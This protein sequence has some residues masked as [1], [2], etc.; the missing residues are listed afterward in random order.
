MKDFYKK[1]THRHFITAFVII[2]II[3][4]VLLSYNDIYTYF[5]TTADALTLIETS[6][7]QS[8][9]DIVR[10]FTKHMMSD[11][12]FESLARYYRPI[13]ML[14]FSLDY[15]IWKLNPL[16]YHLTDLIIH[17]LVSITVFFLMQLLTGGRSFIAWVI[18]IIFT[19]HPAHIEVV[20]GIARRFDT[21]STLCMIFSLLIFLK[22]YHSP[23]YK[24]LL[25]SIF[26]YLLAL[27]SKESA[28]L[29]SPLI[30]IY[31]IIFSSLKPFKIKIGHAIK[32]CFPYFILTFTY[33]LW[34]IYVLHGIGGRVKLS[35]SFS[36]ISTIIQSLI[37]IIVMYFVDLLYSVDF[38][39]FGLLFNNLILIFLT[40]ICLLLIYKKILKIDYQSKKIMKFLRVLFVISFI[41]S[42]TGILIS[43]FISSYISQLIFGASFDEKIDLIIH[44]I[45]VRYPLPAEYNKIDLIFKLLFSF[46]MFLSGFCLIV[47]YKY[48]D[49]KNYFIFSSS[50]KLMGFL[51]IW[52]FLPLSIYLPALTFTHPNIYSSIIPFSAFITLIV[53]EQYQSIIQ[54]T[55]KEKKINISNIFSFTL[56]LILIIFSLSY[57]PLI[58]TYKD[59]KVASNLYVKFFYKLSSLI[60][61]LPNDSTIYIYNLPQII[62]SSDIRIPRVYTA[63]Y[64]T[65]YSIKSWLNLNYPHNNIE[66]VSIN[67]GGIFT[68]ISEIKIEME[69]KKNNKIVNIFIYGERID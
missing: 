18:A 58:R 65:D 30:F 67:R 44:A 7:V 10:I 4:T 32:M 63:T 60:P 28:I 40:V 22:H 26:F 42:A 43:P 59:W 54:R 38:L 11:T 39:V 53:I 20:P 34:R 49:I 47:F 9:N 66:I 41:L 6:R 2:S 21:I 56:I 8:F 46:F 61:K 27:G 64:L 57:S 36:D 45:E 14:T 35:H 1:F 51:L 33:L 69:K 48:K 16:G 50:G 24:R 31:S 19:I 29:L 55:R 5:F 52:L 68:S 23:S 37:K 15:S 62:F 3:S 12:K 17:I 25:F 13:G